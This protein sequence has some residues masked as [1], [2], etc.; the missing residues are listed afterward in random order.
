MVCSRGR[1]GGVV[2]HDGDLVLDRM[3]LTGRTCLGLVLD[4]LQQGQGGLLVEQHLAQGPVVGGRGMLKHA[5]HRRLHAGWP[6]LARRPVGQAQA[7]KVGAVL[8]CRPGGN[9][10]WPAST[11]CRNRSASWCGSVIVVFS[12]AGGYAAPSGR[13]LRYGVLGGLSSAWASRRRRSFLPASFRASR[14]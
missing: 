13:S 11:A 8:L 4:V 10:A 9:E 3:I 12:P 5:F 1:D 2:D 7:E 6:A 14:K